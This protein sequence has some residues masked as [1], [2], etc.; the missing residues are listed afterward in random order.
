MEN[1][2]NKTIKNLKFAFVHE[3]QIRCLY[4]IF[5]QRAS[6]EGYTLISNFLE[7]M[8]SNKQQNAYWNYMMLQKIASKGPIEESS[9]TF[10]DI[11]SIGNTSQNLLTAMKI[12]DYEWRVMYKDYAEEALEER[13]EEIASRFQAISERERKFFERFKIFSE[14]FD[15]NKLIRNES[16]VVWECQGCRFQIH[17]ESL[18]DDWICPSCGHMKPY[19]QKKYLNISQGSTDIWVCMEC[20]EEVYMKS[21]P[22]GF[23]CPNCGKSSEYFRR[24]KAENITD[25]IF[26]VSETIWECMECGNEVRMK[27]IP[28]NWRCISCSKPK[29]YFKRKSGKP[30]TTKYA[31]KK[32]EK[33]I[34]Y[35]P[36]CG[37][38]V[39]IELPEDWTCPYCGSKV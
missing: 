21:L 29:S 13:Y 15:E 11:P 36:M 19:F 4:E 32:R 34:W 25:D 31:F 3:S 1:V 5:A 16:V 38:E 14:L 12:E 22:E 9:V 27:E 39:E 8:A 30:D 33:A 18:P 26:S 35:C 28:E 10:E 37:R 17:K 23:K 7:D 20:G 24:K 2:V 6:K